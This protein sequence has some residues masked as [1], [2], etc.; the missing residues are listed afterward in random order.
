LINTQEQRW[1]QRRLEQTQN[2]FNFSADKKK[3]IFN[4]LNKAEGLEKYRLTNL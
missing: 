2:R 4:L 3:Q 1:L